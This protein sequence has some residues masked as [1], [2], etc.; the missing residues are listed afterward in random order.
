MKYL[1]KYIFLFGLCVGLLA[2]CNKKDIEDPTIA[3]ELEFSNIAAPNTGVK[4]AFTVTAPGR[5]VASSESPWIQLSPASGLETTTCELIVDSSVLNE[6]REGTIRFSSEN[7]EVK[8]LTVTQFGF[9]K[10]IILSTNDTIIESSAAYD[11]R[12]TIVNVSTNVDLKNKIVDGLS[13]A[14]NPATVSWIKCANANDVNLEATGARPQAFKL[15]F[16]WESNLKPE[17]RV[18][19]VMF[20]STALADTVNLIIRQKAGPVI[21][22]DVA[23]DSLALLIVYEKLN[24]T[25]VLNTTEKLSFWEGVTVWQKTD[26][27]VKLNPDMLGRIR[28]LEIKYFKCL[29]A[30]PVE[31]GSFKYLES[32][33]IGTNANKST[34]SIDLSKSDDGIGNLTNLKELTIFAY[35]LVGNVPAT[36]KNLKKLETLSLSS[37]N[38]ASIPAN[39]TEANFPAL[40]NLNF[41]ANRR[42]VSVTLNPLSA[43]LSEIGLH[44]TGSSFYFKR[45][46]QWENLEYIGFSNC[47]LEGN[48]PTAADL[49]INEVYTAADFAEKGDTLNYLIGKPKVMPNLKTLRLNLN[50]FNGSIPDWI[51]Y[52][53]NLMYWDPWTLLYNQDGKK[54]NTAGE[55]IGF[56]NVPVSWN[57]YW[58]A[59][60]LLKPNRDN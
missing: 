60:P 35:G 25:R 3:F 43:P 20:I 6:A 36:W 45:L 32:L 52:H 4:E 22:D 15:R 57:Y 38:L 28:S 12:Y 10:A 40:K 9:E 31:I 39:L 53:P 50:F 42:Y 17:E 29:E 8:T 59:F 21:T 34:L 56:D 19:R 14:V 55:P 44:V 13:E 49:N 27:E 30:I 58:D 41:S 51:L 54:L 46:L 47:V 24:M 5:W 18:A 16:D 23:G 11:S 26:K 48:I 33:N 2:A 1:L 7:G 37:N